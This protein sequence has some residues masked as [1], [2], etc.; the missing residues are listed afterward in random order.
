VLP[1]EQFCFRWQLE[2]PESDQ[3]GYCGQKLTWLLDHGYEVGNH[4]LNHQDLYDVDNRTFQAEIAGAIDAAQA[5]DPRATADILAMPLGNYP[6]SDDHA[7]QR[8][9]L[10]TGFE[11]D[12]R[13]VTLIG[14][15]MVGAEPAASPVSTDW[16]AVFIP[17]I[18]A[19][20]TDEYGVTAFWFPLFAAEPDQ[21][22]ISD[23]DPSTITVP[24]DLPVGLDGTLDETTIAAQGKQL[25]RY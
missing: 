3:Y 25:I 7:Q 11:V 9:W 1:S 6:D 22:Y 19:A 15:L 14:C 21:L 23:G 12:G 2:E 5:Y 17:R 16:D 18:Q 13:P 8:A 10:R 24:L 4:T 20:D